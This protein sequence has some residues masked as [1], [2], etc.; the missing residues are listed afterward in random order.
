MDTLRLNQENREEL[1]AMHPLFSLLS[2]EDKKILAELMYEIYV[3]AGSKIVSEGDLVD[4][5]YLIA[6]GVAEVTRHPVS[7]SIKADVVVAKLSRGEAIGF[8]TSDFFSKTGIRTATVT[9]L[10]STLLLGIGIDSFNHFMKKPERLYAG[11]QK[12]SNMILKMNL[13]KRAEPFAELK[14]EQ[15]Y[16]LV[17]RIEEVQVSANQFIFKQGDESHSCYLIQEGVVEIIKMTA[18]NQEAKT[19]LKPLAI[20]G[21]SSLLTLNHHNVSAKA[22]TECH[23]LLLQKKQFEEVLHHDIFLNNKKDAVSIERV[24]EKLFYQHF[25]PNIVSDIQ[26]TEDKTTD[27]PIFTLKNPKTNSYYQLSS[28][29]LFVWNLLNGSN[30]LDTIINRFNQKFHTK[31]D[32]TVLKLLIELSQAQFLDPPLPT[33]EFK[34]KN[35]KSF[36]EKILSLFK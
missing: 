9:S 15:L 3:P 24:K 35:K 21:L 11:L 1:I 5:V 25:L 13:I 17:Q 2:V 12:V 7:T 22:L 36:L 16:K 31:D 19:L 26:I 32:Q 18:D 10:S 30:S 6:G 20:F 8:T 4:S 29:G 28:E 23:L 27:E 33:L 34:S 14:P